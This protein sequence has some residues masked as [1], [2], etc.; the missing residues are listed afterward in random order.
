MRVPEANYSQLG[1]NRHPFLGLTI[2]N[3]N[4]TD[5]SYCRGHK[6]LTYPMPFKERSH[7]SRCCRP[8]HLD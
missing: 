3:Q 8:S 4:S 7:K 6:G 1:K 2:E 5:V